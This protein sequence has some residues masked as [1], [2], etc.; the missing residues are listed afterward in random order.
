[1]ALPAVRLR[2]LHLALSTFG[3]ALVGREMILADPRVFGLHGLSVGRPEVLGL[4]TSSDAAFATWCAV[5]FVVLAVMVGSVR[6]SWFGRQLTAIRDSELAAGTLGLNVR[7]S[8]MVAFA[9]SGF[10]AGCAGS[11]F[12]GLSG[13]VQGTQFDPVQS[14]VILLLAYVGGITTVVGALIAGTLFALLDY[15]QSTYPDLAGHRVHRRR[16]RRRRPRPPAQRP[17][18][19]HH[20]RRQLLPPPR[21]CL[22]R[23]LRADRG[24][25]PTDA[26]PGAPSAEPV[27][28]A[29]STAS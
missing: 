6:R 27:P 12:G 11:L 9:L 10:I 3:L 18:R 7:R 29:T 4:S 1:M 21:H 16:R 26:A 22:D 13:A 25:P 2:G 14:I 15:S 8:K 5:V 20:Q 17:C 23:A 19:R 28:V 24:S